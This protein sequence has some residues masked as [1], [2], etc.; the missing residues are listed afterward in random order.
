MIFMKHSINLMTAKYTLL[1]YLS[2]SYNW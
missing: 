2:I 1:P